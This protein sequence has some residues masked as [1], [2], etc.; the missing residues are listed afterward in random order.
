MNVLRNAVA[1]GYRNFS[2]MAKDKDLDI[3]RDREDFKALL[4]EMEA[5]QKKIKS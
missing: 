4:A 2:H 3:L 1:K 5:A